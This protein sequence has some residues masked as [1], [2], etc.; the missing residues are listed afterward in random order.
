MLDVWGRTG[1]VGRVADILERKGRVADGLLA[2]LGDGRLR[3][4]MAMNAVFETK[5]DK[6]EKR[7]K[8]L[9]YEKESKEVREGST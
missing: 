7:G 5:N 9:C 8:T 1:T 3:I 2:F 4:P 6:K